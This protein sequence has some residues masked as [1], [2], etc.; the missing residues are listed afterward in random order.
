M[1]CLKCKIET[2]DKF[3][4]NCGG[5]TV[6]SNT[7]C[8]VC[9]VEGK[10][11]FCGKCGNAT[12]VNNEIAS[13]VEDQETNLQFSQANNTNRKSKT[14]VLDSKTNIKKTIKLVIILVVLVG[15]FTGYKVLQSKYT[16]QKSVNQ[17]YTYLANKDYQNAYKMLSNTD[18]DFLNEDMFIKSVEK[19]NFKNYSIKDFNKEDF[20][21]SK[22][23]TSNATT[24]EVQAN[25]VTSVAEVEQTG[26]EFLIFN[27]FKI[28]A[29]NF[30]SKDW[31][32]DVP[33]GTEIFVNG[34]K[35]N[36]LAE[37]TENGSSAATGLTGTTEVYKTKMDNYQIS[38]IFTGNY[39]V[40]LKL[41]GASDIN[42]N[43]VAVGTKVSADFKM[44]KGLEQQ[45]QSQ[46]KK[47]LMAYYA[48]SDMSKF[49]SSDND[50]ES[51]LKDAEQMWNINGTKPQSRGI[52]KNDLAIESSSVGDSTH[53]SI[54]ETYTLNKPVMSVD[55]TVLG[56]PDSP[57]T[58]T[59]Y[60]EKVGN[61]WL[62]CSANL[63]N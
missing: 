18:N 19:Q 7:Y 25:G 13:T 14:K 21:E 15:G 6:A 51:E 55:K 54:V 59:F 62:I 10:D 12:V 48:N 11:Q 35:V 31:G 60:F 30:T 34:K 22:D 39:T 4:E 56:N 1:F 24:Y 28:N 16:P 49:L 5:A 2:E 45:L 61:K 57:I 20:E 47:L 23:I 9:G 42:L 37:N 33:K 26:K 32:F 46:T 58:T 36:N 38:N 29:K 63:Y 8:P 53:A 41:V 17:Y 50:V 52:M 44:T 27:K 3:C 43:E 40:K